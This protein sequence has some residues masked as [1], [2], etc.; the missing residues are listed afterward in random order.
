MEYELLMR[1]KYSSSYKTR[2]NLEIH[3]GITR[4]ISGVY[5]RKISGFCNPQET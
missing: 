3:F 4:R 2:K 5:H 1:I